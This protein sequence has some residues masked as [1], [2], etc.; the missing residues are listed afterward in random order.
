MSNT[1]IILGMVPMALGI[2]SSGAEMRQ[3][4]GM[5]IIGGILSSMVLTLLLIPALEYLSSPRHV[6]EE[7]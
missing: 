4:M 3:P 5:V 7:F 2:G 6:N 1:A